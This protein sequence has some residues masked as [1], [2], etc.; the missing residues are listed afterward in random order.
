MPVGQTNRRSFIAGL[1]TVAMCPLGALAQQVPTVGY[2][3]A[4]S[5]EINAERGGV[6]CLN[7][8]SASISGAFCRVKLP[9]GTAVG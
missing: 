2:L 6:G 7:R 1:G 4:L 5:R 3:H 8:F 9:R